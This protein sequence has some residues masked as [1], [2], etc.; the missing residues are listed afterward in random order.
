MLRVRAGHR[1]SR[2]PVLKSRRTCSASVA[3]PIMSLGQHGF[4]IFY[5]LLGERKPRFSHG[6]KRQSVFGIGNSL[7]KLNA[8]GG[9]QAI[10][11]YKFIRGQCI[12][13]HGTQHPRTLNGSPARWFP[14]CTKFALKQP[15]IG[16]IG[17]CARQKA[18]KRH[19]I[20]VDIAKLPDL[21]SS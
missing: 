7:G 17:D 3:A 21:L 20:A 5:R 16:G 19:R 6:E 11:R 12:S 15:A 1:R 2:L 8:M 14:Q 9:V 4:A 10:T 18:L 13:P